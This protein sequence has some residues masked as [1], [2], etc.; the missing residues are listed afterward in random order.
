MKNDYFLLFPVLYAKPWKYKEVT[1][2]SGWMFHK[3]QLFYSF[4][5]CETLN[6][7]DHARYYHAGGVSKFIFAARSTRTLRTKL[8][9]IL[10][11]WGTQLHTAKRHSRPTGGNEI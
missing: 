6:F 2:T 8:N 11:N 4:N 3:R 9:G 7:A 5:S 10:A 1:G